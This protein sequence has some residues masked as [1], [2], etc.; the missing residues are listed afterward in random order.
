MEKGLGML[1]ML[2]H[3]CLA[4]TEEEEKNSKRESCVK[5]LGG[6]WLGCVLVRMKRDEQRNSSTPSH[7]ACHAMLSM[8]DVDVV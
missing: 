7:H 5:V 8:C 3:V 4:C 6:I 1:A 2:L